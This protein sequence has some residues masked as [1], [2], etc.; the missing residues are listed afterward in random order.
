MEPLGNAGCVKAVPLRMLSL[1]S[2]ESQP[3]EPR[4]SRTKPS[5]QMKRGQLPL[6]KEGRQG[7]RTGAV[8]GRGKWKQRPR[9]PGFKGS[10]MGSA[11]PVYDV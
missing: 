6:Q 3:P 11:Y 4:G 7:S 8:G 10:Q 1:S 5:W 9:N 2:L